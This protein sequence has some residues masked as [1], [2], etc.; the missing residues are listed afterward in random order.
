[1][2]QFFFSFVSA[3]DINHHTKIWIAVSV[4][5]AV[6]TYESRDYDSFRQSLWNQ[7]TYQSLPN[8]HQFLPKSLSLGLA[9]YHIKSHL[10]RE[11]GAEGSRPSSG[12]CGRGYRQISPYSIIS[13]AAARG[14]ALQDEALLPRR[15]H[16]HVL[17]VH[18]QQHGGAHCRVVTTSRVRRVST[19][20]S[21]SIVDWNQIDRG[22]QQEE[23]GEA[24]QPCTFQYFIVLYI[25]WRIR[26][27]ILVHIQFLNLWH[28]VL[29]SQVVATIPQQAW[30]AIQ[31]P[32]LA[33][34]S[35]CISPVLPGI[36]P[37]ELTKVDSPFGVWH[38]CLLNVYAWY[39]FVAP[40]SSSMSGPWWRIPEEVVEEEREQSTRA[41]QGRDLRPKKET[42]RNKNRICLLLDPPFHP[43][44]LL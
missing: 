33:L 37:V 11:Q 14:D 30:K 44:C 9:P 18:R 8:Y 15:H 22:V 6:N 25:Q 17:D 36:L 39:L 27:M 42:N 2:E 32:P 20:P 35:S 29:I 3:H 24:R 26:Q 16:L 31:I 28:G 7:I 43:T 13:L 38:A 21:D 34:S 12:R 4:N 10:P 41:Q 23:E 1:L 40:L 5:H 19:S